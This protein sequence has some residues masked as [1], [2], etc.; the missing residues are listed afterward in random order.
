ME[1]DECAC[2]AH[3]TD[4]P[5][6]SVRLPRGFTHLPIEQVVHE[7]AALVGIPEPISRNM[8]MIEEATSWR[9]EDRASIGAESSSGDSTSG[10][11]T[12]S[13]EDFVDSARE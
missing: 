11:H 7:A 8:A 3:G 1:I 4:H 10:A 12:S 9:E 5:A 2:C 6:R 13:N